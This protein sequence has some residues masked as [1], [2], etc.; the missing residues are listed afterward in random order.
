MWL[1]GPS[2]VDPGITSPPIA[3]GS[4]ARRSENQDPTVVLVGPEG[5]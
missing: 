4:E 2:A 5:T 1:V 3:C